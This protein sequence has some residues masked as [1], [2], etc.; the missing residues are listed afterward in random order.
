M[1]LPAGEKTVPGRRNSH[2]KSSEAENADVC[3]RRQRGWSRGGQGHLGRRRQCR[4][5]HQGHSLLGKMRVVLTEH[6]QP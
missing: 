1:D 3:A 2:S 5:P 6:Q 4:D